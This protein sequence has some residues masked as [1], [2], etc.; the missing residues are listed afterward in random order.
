MKRVHAV[1]FL[2]AAAA[3]ALGLVF[4]S[5]VPVGGAAVD[6]YF[7]GK[8]DGRLD[9]CDCFGYPSAGLVKLAAEL[10][11][12]D[13]ASSVLL[14][15]GDLFEAGGDLPLARELIGS[16]EDL[17][18][19][20]AAVGDQEFSSGADFIR[21]AAEI[22]GPFGS[23]NLRWDGLPVGT[24]TRAFARGGMRVLALSLTGE[25]S[26]VLFPVAFRA[27]LQ[28]DEPVGAA[29]RA[30]SEARGDSGKDADLIALAYHGSVAAAERVGS[31]VR[32]AAPRSAVV[33]I[34]AHADELL[35]APRGGRLD[36][37]ERVD[38]PRA[39]RVEVL[40]PSAPVF[41]LGSGASRIGRI[42]V[43]RPLLAVLG[44]PLRA[45]VARAEYMVRN[46][47]RDADDLPTRTRVLR[48]NTTFTAVTGI[49]RDIEISF[50]SSSRDAV[51]SAFPTPL[52]L[53]Y[54]YSPTCE[55]CL[56][57]LREALP[58]IAEAERRSFTIKRRNIMMS[59]DFEALQAALRERGLE[60][61]GVPVL[62]GPSGVLQGEAAIAAGLSDFLSADRAVS[63]RSAPLGVVSGSPVG[64]GLDRPALAAV[65]AAGF[66]DGIN[67]CAFST[68][69]FLLSSLALAGAGR[70][71]LVRTGIAFCAGVF[72][73]YFAV[74][75]GAFAAL[76]GGESL[77]VFSAVFR[78]ATV[79]LLGVGAVLSLIDA[80]RA[81][82]GESSAMILQL[83]S[84]AKRRI[85][86]LV[87]GYRRGGAAA[88]GALA[89]GAA[90]SVLELGCTGQVY[91]P[92]LV[93]LARSEGGFANLAFLALYDLA[94]I[95]PLL[96]VFLAASR[97]ISSRAVAAFFSARIHVVKIATAVLLVGFA[98][99]LMI[100]R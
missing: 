44:V 47:L 88:V 95:L 16:L 69:V 67:P 29:L 81:L 58:R 26:F 78:W 99:V 2:V 3:V 92:T 77:P 53:E 34:A 96:A 12:R 56:D 54:Y 48:Y 73:A 98:A 64:P 1:A 59:A 79:A 68:V 63:S 94:F 57:F 32:A 84:A 24:G 61:L 36:R 97:G 17:G 87:R 40:D 80:R 15:A 52:E 22:G 18:Y 66:V 14:D 41:S 4:A 45:R 9:G 72:G 49:E 31:A 27:R 8:I 76:R 38:L 89:L 5:L 65:L 6:V 83:P 25:E 86:D 100:P 23:A 33:V 85:H 51:G 70:A 75:L 28:I 93:Y 35:P 91:L 37:L 20:L 82:R 43:A 60:F 7:T 90:V 10:R 46:Y 39:K 55:S 74:G 21:A 30:V 71:T 13:R 42:R 19:D 50:G 11:D 62:V